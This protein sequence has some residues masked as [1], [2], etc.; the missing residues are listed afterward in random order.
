M[1]NVKDH[2]RNEERDK[3]NMKNNF[4]NSRDV[5]RIFINMRI[6]PNIISIT[7]C[8]NLNKIGN[9]NF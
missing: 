7:V 9:M 3:Y 1:V 2:N 8:V 4:D 5:Y 6:I